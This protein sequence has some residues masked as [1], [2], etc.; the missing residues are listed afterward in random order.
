VFIDSLD[1][2]PFCGGVFDEGDNL[3]E[4]CFVDREEGMEEGVCREFRDWDGLLKDDF[5]CKGNQ[6]R[7][8]E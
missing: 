5:V 8:F 3:S 7:F 4:C 2:I 6:V 1:V